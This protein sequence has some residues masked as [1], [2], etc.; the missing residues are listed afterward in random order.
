L[1]TYYVAADDLELLI[2]LPQGWELED[3]CANT[4]ILCHAGDGAQ[5]LMHARC[6]CFYM[7]T[8][9]ET[10]QNYQG[11]NSIGYISENLQVAKRKELALE[12]L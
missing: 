9:F 4:P 1:R 8:I 12:T 7:S 2:L 11:N 10:H 3:V 6:T 5:G